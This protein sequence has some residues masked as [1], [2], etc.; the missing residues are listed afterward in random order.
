MIA[1]LLESA[2]TRAE[3]QEYPLAL[4]KIQELLALDPANGAALALKNSIE[5]RRS[6]QKI[7]DWF[8]L[9]RQH[10][11]QSAFSHARQ[12]LQNVLQLKPGDSRAR[13]LMTEVDRREQ[14]FVRA[15]QEKEELYAKALEAWQSG[16]VSAALSKLESLVSLER[17]PARP[18][19]PSAPPPSRASTT[20][21]APSTMPSRALTKARAGSWWTASSTTR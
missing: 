17:T 8:R 1:Q 14:E 3:E 12:A 4:Q 18:R 16:E 19:R 15:S 13:K 10:M 6:E 5:N 7:E 9:A 21:C 11:E 2:R 20:R